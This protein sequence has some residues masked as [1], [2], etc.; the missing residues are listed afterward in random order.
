[1]PNHSLSSSSSHTT[2]LLF[3]VLGAVG[4]LT[5]LAIDMYLPA[6]PNLARD[7]GVAEGSV[8]ITL[9]VYTAG[10]AIGQLIQ[11]PLADSYGRRPVL[12]IGVALFA[13]A[14]VMSALAQGI[15]ALIL[16][17][18]I[19]GFAGAAAAV[20]IQAIVR[21]MFDREDFSR[22]M[23]FI[24][25]VITIA[26]LIA[27]LLGGYIAIWFG[28]RGIFWVLA[29]FSLIVIALVLW[30]I[31]ETLREEN[32][33]PLNLVS[34]LKHY[35]G[36]CRNPVV[37]GLIFSGAFS[38]AGMFSFLTAGSFVYINI[39]HVEPNEF[40]YL[41]ALN[42]IAM[43]IMTMINGR[44]VKKIGSHAMLK[45]ALSIQLFAGVGLFVGWILD[46]GLW[47]TV[48]FVVLFVG[49]T[50]TIGSNTMALL[51][52]GYPTMAGTVS[53]LAGTLRFGTGSVMGGTIAFM[54]DGV[55]WPMISIMTTCSIL[56]TMCYWIFGRKA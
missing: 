6:M 47:G 29:V 41:F 42:I 20:I 40:G 25:L 56:S 14:S 38:F 43:I 12:I 32:R 35:A 17:R 18:G 7:L 30:K 21:D 36:L 45:L 44:F 10:F 4:A 54:P 31:P 28:W 13:V 24:T 11:G 26:P 52:S 50:A 37:V 48:P 55:V 27:P 9:T 23:S 46:L 2:Y 49:T 16:I 39:Y 15:D 53:S 1:M 5:P 22:A 33:Q 34:I 51:L 3:F 19:Q 8:Q